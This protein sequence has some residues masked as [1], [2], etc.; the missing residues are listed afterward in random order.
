MKRT[1][2]VA[3]V[4]VGLATISA[5]LALGQAPSQPQMPMGPGQGMGGGAMGPGMGQGQPGGPGMMGPGMGPGM[6]GRGSM[7]PG[8]QLGDSEERP[9]ISLMLRFRQQLALSNEQVGKLTALRSGFE[10]E[11]IRAGAEIR[12][13]EIELDD[14]LDQE[15]VDLGK[16]E[17]AIRKEE[18]LRGNL[19]LSRVK[20]IEAGK[21]ILTAEQR[22]K[23]KKNLEGGSGMGMMGSGM[24]G[25]GMMGPGMMGPGGQGQGMMM[26]PQMMQQMMG[27][28]M[29]Q[30]AGAGASASPTG[31]ATSK[32]TDA[33]GPVTVEATLLDPGKAGDRI[34]VE[35]VLDTHSAELDGYKL[36]ALT[37]LRT[38]TGKAVQPLGLESPSGSGHHRKGVLVFPG[39]DAGGSLLEGAKTLELVV[40]DVGGVKERALGWALP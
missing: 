12:V 26:G 6:M 19:R 10:K 35:I 21:A 27:G 31:Q 15:K 40:R 22:D 8:G 3:T 36:E 7:G 23:L 4:V 38:D 13:V 11:A 17:A 5:G 2:L 39:K 34:R 33:T 18:S 28:G 20:T 1:L 30:Q 16:V 9:L 25:P 37:T 14:L 29:G 32:R 24:M